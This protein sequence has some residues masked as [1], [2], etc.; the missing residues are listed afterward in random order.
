MRFGSTGVPAVIQIDA[1]GGGVSPTGPRLTPSRRG[2]RRPGGG[3]GGDGQLAR[4]SPWFVPP[5]GAT[6]AGRT[7]HSNQ[8]RLSLKATNFVPSPDFKRSS[9]VRLPSRC[10]LLIPARTSAGEATLRPATSGMTS[11]AFKP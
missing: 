1:G 10:A 8:A 9:T 2:R 5:A 4:P 3:I 11:P 6:D 7:P